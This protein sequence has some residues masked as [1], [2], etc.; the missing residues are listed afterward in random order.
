M[1]ILMHG[2]ITFL[3][4]IVPYTTPSKKRQ[5][6]ASSFCQT[7]DISEV[8]LPQYALPIADMLHLAS[9][10]LAST[11]PGH[12]AYATARVSLCVPLGLSNTRG[13]RF[14]ALHAYRTMLFIRVASKGRQDC[15]TGP[16]L[17]MNSFQPI[18]TILFH[19][20]AFQHP[21]EAVLGVTFTNEMP[22]VGR[23]RLSQIRPARC[24]KRPR[25][26]LFSAYALWLTPLM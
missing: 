23:R 16:T 20:T 18:A 12:S 19:P 9:S 8:R 5:P 24:W 11:F 13:L 7:H 10:Y 21:L 26:Q 1:L 15:P 2:V 6:M 14:K 4:V 17:H 25:P 22:T 3:N